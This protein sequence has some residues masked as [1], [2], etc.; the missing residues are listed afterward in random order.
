MLPPR[1]ADWAPKISLFD[2]S[3]PVS[4]KMA[5]FETKPQFLW[6]PGLSN[7]I[8]AWEKTRPQEKRQRNI[9]WVQD[10]SRGSAVSPR[11]RC[12]EAQGKGQAQETEG[13]G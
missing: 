7:R 6:D 5:R 13:Q 10:A 1:M 4:R 12:G 8:R 9:R 2:L 3:D 11:S